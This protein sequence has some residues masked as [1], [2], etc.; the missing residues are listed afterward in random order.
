MSPHT[1]KCLITAGLLCLTLAACSSP[2]ANFYT[3][4]SATS[5]MQ[6]NP[7]DND[8][9]LPYLYS[10][11]PNWRDYDK[12]IVDPP[13]IYRDQDNQFGDLSEK[14][15]AMLASYMQDRFSGMLRGRFALVQKPSERT[16]RLKLTLTGV[17][18]NTPVLSTFARFDLAGGLYNGIQSIRGHEGALSGAVMYAVE[19][20]DAQNNT[21]LESFIAKQ[22]PNA[23]NIGASIGSLAAAKTGIEKGADSLREKLQ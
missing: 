7:K 9:R 4:L 18:T 1:C 10:A 23:M 5:Q 22:Y 11:H 12:I 2:A 17:E 13:A 6:P 20:Y 19:I 8:G 21:L 16:L 3:G 14:D 15:K